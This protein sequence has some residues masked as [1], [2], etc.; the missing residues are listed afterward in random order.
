M[1][2][3]HLPLV[4]G[5]QPL[6]LA[7]LTLPPHISVSLGQLHPGGETGIQVRSSEGSLGTVNMAVFLPNTTARPEF[8][9]MLDIRAAT[10]YAGID[11]PPPIAKC[12]LLWVQNAPSLIFIRFDLGCLQFCRAWRC[13]VKE[14]GCAP[15][16]WR[17]RYFT[18]ASRFPGWKVKLHPP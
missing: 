5:R 8:L 7:S 18:Q 15:R 9:D 3:V 17:S 10:G 1:V 11:L 14:P 2:L 12:T 6:A 4:F 16:K 13:Q